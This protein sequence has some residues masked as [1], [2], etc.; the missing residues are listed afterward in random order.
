M[1]IRLLTFL[2]RFSFTSVKISQSPSQEP[3]RR[4]GKAKLMRPMQ[5]FNELSLAN[6]SEDY[7]P[8]F[9]KSFSNRYKVQSS[10]PERHQSQNLLHGLSQGP[11]PGYMGWPRTV[12]GLQRLRQYLSEPGPPLLVPALPT[13]P[14]A[15]LALHSS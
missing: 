14:G 2:L 3:W 11:T 12:P 9:F 15:S 6:E 5:R 8:V 13:I 7:S 10:S 1:F 4:A